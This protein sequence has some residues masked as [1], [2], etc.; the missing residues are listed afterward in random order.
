MILFQVMLAVS[1]SVA[2]KFV[3][4]ESILGAAKRVSLQCSIWALDLVITAPTGIL[5]MNIYNE[6]LIILIT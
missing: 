2:G 4:L 5:D 6:K 3:T 1:V